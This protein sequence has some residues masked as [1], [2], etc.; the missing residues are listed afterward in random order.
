MIP[1]QSFGSCRASSGG[2]AENGRRPGEGRATDK[3]QGHQPAER[4]MR[5]SHIDVTM[6]NS[7][8]TA[9]CKL[10][11]GGKHLGANYKKILRLS[12]DVIIT[13]DNR[14]SNLR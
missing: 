6:L 3:G 10:I 2:G 4:S 13:Y 8:P 7:S 12:Y 9:S 11:A 5:V 1:S 14:K